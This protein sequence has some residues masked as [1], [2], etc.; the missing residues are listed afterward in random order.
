MILRDGAVW[1]EA[2]AVVVAVIWD[3]VHI[4]LVSDR[5]SALEKEI[6][7]VHQNPEKHDKDRNQP[8]PMG[9]QPGADP[10]KNP[11]Q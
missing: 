2:V 7:P 6:H 10:S 1:F 3:A 9:R 5:V 11:G 4:C 8:L